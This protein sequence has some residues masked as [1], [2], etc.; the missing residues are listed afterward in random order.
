MDMAMSVSA[1]QALLT[2]L[3]RSAIFQEEGNKI[4]SNHSWIV[5][6]IELITLS[7]TM[8]VS[9][10]TRRALCIF[11]EEEHAATHSQRSKE[12]L[13]LYSILNWVQTPMSKAL[14]RRWLQF[15][16]RSLSILSER[17]DAV[18]L[19]LQNKR[20]C[21]L[22]RQEIKGIR[23]MERSIA[24]ML[25]G[26]ADLSTWRSVSDFV[27]KCI[28]IRSHVT[29]LDDIS[30]ETPIIETII[31]TF[32]TDRLRKVGQSIQDVI[33]WDESRFSQR[34]CVKEGLDAQLD[35]WRQAYFNLPSILASIAAKVSG[36]LGDALKDVYD[37]YIEYFPQV[38]Y[39][40]AL[41]RR[42][43]GVVDEDSIQLG[44]E[45]GWKYQYSSEIKAYFKTEEAKDLDGQLGD[46][47]SFIAGRE[48]EIIQGLYGDMAQHLNWLTTCSDI[49]A[50]LDCLL[51]FAVVADRN[52]YVRP[53]VTEIPILDIQD[54][55][56][57]L[58]ELIVETFVPNSTAVEGGR[59]LGVREDEERYNSIAIVTGANACGKSIYLKQTALIVYMAQVGSFVPASRATIGVVDK[60]K[61]K[62]N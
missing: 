41:C 56:H 52:G 58:Q 25:D 15:P 62:L 20:L 16:S 47:H 55:R 35:E 60:S 37:M 4:I 61:W 36:T 14:L 46:L 53:V 23:N 2:H 42:D 50:K 18:E 3:Q 1:A 40:Q 44:E 45:L 24:R 34:I 10:D 38:G 31:G 30:K 7:D 28:V 22:L 39:L 57:P 29:T 51:A 59:G 54:G 12:G 27:F 32:T 33:N 26:N 11:D 17:Y 5:T 49:V 19:F 13:S 8:F 48:I 43:G 6:R 21:E 9:G